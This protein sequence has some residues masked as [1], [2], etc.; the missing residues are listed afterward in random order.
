MKPW[1]QWNAPLGLVQILVLGF[2]LMAIE[3]AWFLLAIP[4]LSSL[5][6]AQQDFSDQHPFLYEIVRGSIAFMLLPLMA[7][8]TFAYGYFYQRHYD[9]KMERGKTG[10]DIVR[11]HMHTTP[12]VQPAVDERVRFRRLLALVALLSVAWIGRFVF[13]SALKQRMAL[14]ASAWVCGS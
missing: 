12:S 8:Y 7:G 11:R 1:R 2:S 14:L 6:A 3:F 13:C 5:L 10:A 4:Y 9:R